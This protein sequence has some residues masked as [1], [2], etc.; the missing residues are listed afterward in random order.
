MPAPQLPPSA[1]PDTSTV[2]LAA[3]SS[4]DGGGPARDP[5]GLRSEQD[6]VRCEGQDC[7]TLSVCL[8]IGC[9]RGCH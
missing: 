6:I 9:M 2:G 8:A 3:Q 7:D 4:A 5:K 1:A